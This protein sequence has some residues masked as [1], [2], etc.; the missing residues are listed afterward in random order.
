MLSRQN[1]H[2][3]NRNNI[4]E[5]DPVAGGD[6]EAGYLHRDDGDSLLESNDLHAIVSILADM[7]L[8]SPQRSFALGPEYRLHQAAG[9]PMPI[10]AKRT[11]RLLTLARRSTIAAA[12]I[13]IILLGGLSVASHGHFSAL[14]TNPVAQT[15]HY[16]EDSSSG[17]LL[18]ERGDAA[19]AA[20][21]PMDDLAGL[22]PGS[23]PAVVPQTT[24]YLPDRAAWRFAL[25]GSAT[26]ALLFGSTWYGLSRAG[27]HARDEGTR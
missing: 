1:Y 27:R 4:H 3:R 2:I 22:A 11:S 25:L 8:Y 12:L 19:S 23:D 5:H 10:E 18:T 16:Q 17:G 13:L 6:P 20:D 7:P 24:G 15:S 21:T 9:L 14:V 26:A